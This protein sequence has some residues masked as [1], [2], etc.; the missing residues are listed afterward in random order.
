MN[1]RRQSSKYLKH[2]QHVT[3]GIIY[4][5]MIWYDTPYPSLERARS[6]TQDALQTAVQQLRGM[7]H[8]AEYMCGMYISYIPYEAYIYIYHDDVPLLMLQCTPHTY[9]CIY[10]MPAL[11]LYQR[12]QQPAADLSMKVKTRT[13]SSMVSRIVQQEQCRRNIC[14]T[15]TSA[16]AGST[17]TS[18][19]DRNGRHL[20]R[21][22]VVC[23]VV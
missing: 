21:S 17:I 7:T 4:V 6:F 20:D 16:V 15:A 13:F 18:H 12:W 10:H 23:I 9:M 8:T 14:T 2:L 19:F 22:R 11:L 1:T 5:Y 3:C